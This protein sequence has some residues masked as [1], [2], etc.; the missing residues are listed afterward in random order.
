MVED[1]FNYAY[2]S[3]YMYMSMYGYMHMYGCVHVR[4]DACEGWE[5]VLDPLRLD[6]QTT[7]TG[8]AKHGCWELTFS[9]LPEQYPL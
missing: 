7:V 4:T 1:V 9:P 6:L 3:M 5:R 2:M 8:A